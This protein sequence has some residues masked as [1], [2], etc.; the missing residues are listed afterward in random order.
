[1]ATGKSFFSAPFIMARSLLIPNHKS[2]IISVS[3]GQASG[4]FAKLEDLANNNIASVLGVSSVFL[5]NVVRLNSKSSGFTHAKSGSHVELF[6]GSEVTSLN[7]VPDNLRGIRSNLNVYDEGAFIDQELYTAT[8]PFTAVSADFRTS[9]D[10]NPELYPK[11]IPNLNLFLS[12]ASDTSCEMYRQYKEAFRQMMLGN[13]S[14]FVAD[15]NNWGPFTVKCSKN[16]K[17]NC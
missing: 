9:K 2:Y 1:M 12:S 14:Y 5:E 16:N 17:P 11:Q 3:G 8:L 10:L 13:T 15:L 6:N 4:T 7:S